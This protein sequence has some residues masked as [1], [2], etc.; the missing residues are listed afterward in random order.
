MIILAQAS[1]GSTWIFLA[2]GIAIGLV[3]LAAW[4][5]HWIWFFRSFGLFRKLRSFGKDNVVL[6]IMR[7]ELAPLLPG[8]DG[9]RGP[10]RRDNPWVRD[11]GWR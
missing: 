8:R 7:K 4:V 6:N 3:A 10:H 11:L 5:V 1:D 2:L 9:T